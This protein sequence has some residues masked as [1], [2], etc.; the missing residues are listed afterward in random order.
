MWI[1]RKTVQADFPKDTVAHVVDIVVGGSRA[2][3]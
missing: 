1:F 3:K 2:I